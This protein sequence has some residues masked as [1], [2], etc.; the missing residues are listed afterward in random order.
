MFLK[1]KTVDLGHLLPW[2]EREGGGIGAGEKKLEG[3]C[4][5]ESN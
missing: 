2:W 4:T 3:N 1:G 5:R